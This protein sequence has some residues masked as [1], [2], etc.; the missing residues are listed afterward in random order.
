MKV[1]IVR[2]SVRRPSTSHLK[3]RS[4]FFS[5]FTYI[6]DKIRNATR[7]TDQLF[8]RPHAMGH[9]RLYRCKGMSGTAALHIVCNQSSKNVYKKISHKP[10]RGQIVKSQKISVFI[11][12]SCWISSS[13]GNLL[14]RPNV[15]QTILIYARL[16][17]WRDLIKTK[18]FMTISILAFKGKLN[19]KILLLRFFFCRV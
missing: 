16:E 13:N 5:Y 11:M 17:F 18:Y 2:P 15:T 12:L 14:C 3:P 10:S 19:G 1:S 4:R 8:R 9:F 6:P 7:I